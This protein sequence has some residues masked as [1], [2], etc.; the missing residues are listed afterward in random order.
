MSCPSGKVPYPSPQAAHGALSRIRRRSRR[1]H[2]RGKRTGGSAY[3]CPLCGSYHI[4][5]QRR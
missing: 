4:T 5:S 3:R 1:R 2:L